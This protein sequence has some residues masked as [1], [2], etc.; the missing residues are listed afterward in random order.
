[1]PATAEPVPGTERIGSLDILRG[2]AILG[3]LVMNIYVFALPF[4][5][6][7]NPLVM[8][9]TDM[10]N[11]G[12]WFFTHIFVDQKFLSIFAMLFGAGIILMTDRA[13]AREVS[14]GRIFYR[15]QFFM[16][17]LGAVHA[18]FIWFGDILFMY[19]A[20]GML[21]YLFRDRT[22]RTLII[23]AC[24]FL[25]VTL[26]L[27]HGIGW[28]ME[29]TISEVA[30]ITALRDAGELFRQHHCWT[31][32]CQHCHAVDQ[33]WLRA[34]SAAAIRGGW[35]HG[36]DKLPDA[37]SYSDDRVLWLRPGPVWPRA[38][39]LGNGFRGCRDRSADVD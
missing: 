32:A 3:I 23:L 22:P 20:V 4:T 38:A 7:S 17:L 8:G 2:V 11:L 1:M 15:R 18:Y 9:G 6:Y 31:G 35:A 37:F 36:V 28:Q 33:N 13:E 16:M 12:T 29:K 26:L 27:S 25:L 10:L 34:M 30:E 5:A 39:I 19:A 21:A 14:F 24:L